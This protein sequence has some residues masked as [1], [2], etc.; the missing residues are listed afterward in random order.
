[1]AKNKCACGEDLQKAR[2]SER[3]KYHVTYRLPSGKQRRELVGTSWTDA[4]AL[5][6]KKRAQKREGKLFDVLPGAKM[7]FKELTDWFL[8]LEREKALVSYRRR[9]TTLK[10]FNTVFG[11]TV[12]GN[13]KPV[14]LE[15]YQ[16]KRKKEGMADATVDIELGD[17]KTVVYKAFNN[18]IVGGDTL[19]AFKAVK[20]LS[21]ANANARD[22]ILTPEE[23]TRLLAKAAAHLRPILATAYY[24]GMRKGEI[25]KLTWDKV[26]FKDRV[27]RLEATDTKDREKRIVPICESLLEELKAIPRGIHGLVF[28]YQGKGV[29]DIETGMAT[30]CRKAKILYGRFQKGGFTFHDLRHTFNTNM[31][32]AGVSESVIM[33]IT[34]HST[35]AMFDRYNTVDEADREKAVS[36]LKA[37]LGKS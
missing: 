32:K 11:E 10:N 19:R 36:Q 29:T 16:A 21:K 1:M 2:K 4:Q 22:R 7:T 25:L 34:G 13:I 20:N 27:I 24:T 30:A 31:R 12:V 35:R 6:G 5:D 26:D 14:D 28:R 3:V 18:A 15:D 8:S 33:D 23:F 37:F 9:C 17:A